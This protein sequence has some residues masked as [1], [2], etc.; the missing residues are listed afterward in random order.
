MASKLLGILVTTA[1]LAIA[2]QALAEPEAH[3]KVVPSGD[4]AYTFE[5]QDLFGQAFG[6][7]GYV[8]RVHATP[9]HTMLLRPRTSLVPEILHSAEDI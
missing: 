7:T 1:A 4:Y 2:E 3:V 5:D 8:L 6:A 9:M